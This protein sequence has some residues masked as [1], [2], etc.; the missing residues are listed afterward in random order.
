MKRT[1]MFALV[2]CMFAAPHTPPPVG[3]TLASIYVVLALI[4]I[5]REAKEELRRMP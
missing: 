3:L 1:E 2:G 4:S 5:L